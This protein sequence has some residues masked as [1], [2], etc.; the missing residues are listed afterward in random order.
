MNELGGKVARDAMV[1]LVDGKMV[2]CELDGT[3]TYDRFV[4][5]CFLDGADIAI[6]LVEAG[7]ARDC[8]RF[9]R[10]R[11]RQ[12]ETDASRSLRLPKYCR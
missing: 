9:S 3:K 5:I 1:A 12:Y 6:P 2:R 10:G 11:Y 4:G 7:V 8:P